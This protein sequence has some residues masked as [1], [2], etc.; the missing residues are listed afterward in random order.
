M[1]YPK[2]LSQQS[3]SHLF[4]FE[5]LLIKPDTLI[6]LNELKQASIVYASIMDGEDGRYVTWYSKT[7]DEINVNYRRWFEINISIINEGEYL[8]SFDIYDWVQRQDS[9][10]KQQLHSSGLGEIPN[11]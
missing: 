4:K 8:F 3:Y 1:V 9:Y 11:F 6:E 2:I 10:A 5:K 7:R